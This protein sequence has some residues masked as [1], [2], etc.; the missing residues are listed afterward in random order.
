MHYRDGADISL[1]V[2]IKQ[3][4]LVQITGFGDGRIAKFDQ[5]R[6]GFGKVTNFQGTN[7]LSK[8]AL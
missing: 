7:P 6:V 4:V 1:C 8:K 2:Q 5:Y 3:G